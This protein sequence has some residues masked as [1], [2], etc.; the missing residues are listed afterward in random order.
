MQAQ[1][2]NYNEILTEKKQNDI[3]NLSD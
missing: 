2:P 1:K 3:I